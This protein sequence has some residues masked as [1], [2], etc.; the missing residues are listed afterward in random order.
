[1]D[2]VVTV[3][4]GR[5]PFDRLVNAAVPLCSDNRV[6][7]QTGASRLRPPCDH[8]PYVPYPELMRRIEAA[9]V[10]V[11]HAGNTVRLAQR[12]GKIPVAVARTSALGE[13]ANDHQVEY[14]REEAE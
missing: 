1:M 10:V 2:I 7:I 4:M 3:G 11:T 13:M 9:D 14:L 6:F 8:V 12:M 5:W